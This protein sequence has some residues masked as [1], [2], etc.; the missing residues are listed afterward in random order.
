M[1]FLKCRLTVPEAAKIGVLGILPKRGKS[2][3]VIF[4]KFGLEKG[5][6]CI[7]CRAKFHRCRLK[8]VGLQPPKSRKMIIFGINLPLR[9]NS[10]VHKKV[11]FMCTTT[12]LPACNDTV[13]VLKITLLHSVS[14][15]YIAYNFA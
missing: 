15:K 8:N 2:P 4:T 13:I 11:E 9:E 5:L 1:P 7:H 3:L 6:S 12:N 10:G 14:D